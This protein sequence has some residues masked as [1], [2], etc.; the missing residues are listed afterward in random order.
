MN[1]I[2]T[3]RHVRAV[4][5]ITLVAVDLGEMETTETLELF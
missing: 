4:E 1:V 5:M 2:I 3:T